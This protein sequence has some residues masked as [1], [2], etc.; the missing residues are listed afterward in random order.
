MDQESIVYGCIKDDLLSTDSGRRKTNR[1]AM[2]ALPES[3]Q[4]NFITRNMFSVPNFDLIK[5]YQTEIMH[6]GASYRAVEYEWEGWIKEFEHLL[7]KMYWMSAV[8][9]LETELSG[10]HTFYW[11]ARDSYHAPGSK[12]MN[13]R[14]EW[15][16][17]HL[18]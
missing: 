3:D 16:Q 14:C 8:V 11:E 15:Q 9:H 6:F 18:F 13:V 17:D 5:G 2:L 1:D 12:D 10:A 7:S 4:W